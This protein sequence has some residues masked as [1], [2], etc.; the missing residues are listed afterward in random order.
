MGSLT[1]LKIN[2]TF[3]IPCECKNQILSIEYDHL[4]NTAHLVIYENQA[5]Y[6]NKLSLWQR[7]KYCYQIAVNKK[8]YA[9]QISLN[10]NQLKDLEKFLNT[11][12]F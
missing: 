9:D 6:R 12:D 1:N 2:K 8:L 3:F 4:S 11:L 5:S 7:L 10:K